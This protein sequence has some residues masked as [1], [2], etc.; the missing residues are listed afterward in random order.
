VQINTDTF[1]VIDHASSNVGSRG[2]VG[3]SSHGTAR[4][5][6][7]NF[8][9]DL[10]S[11]TADAVETFDRIPTNL[12]EQ[13]TGRSLRLSTVFGHNFGLA[14]LP[15]RSAAFLFVKVSGICPR[16]FD[17]AEAHPINFL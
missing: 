13:V 11:G 4:V 14:A 1:E 6:E 12:W 17:P 9:R 15:R 2:N 7:K 10:S 8:W 3:V 5:H 16:Q